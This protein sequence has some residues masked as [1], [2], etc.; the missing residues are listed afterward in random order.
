MIYCGFGSEFGKV[1]VPASAPD[2]NPDNGSRPYLA[3]LIKKMCKK[4]RVFTVRSSNVSHK[5]G[6]W[7][8]VYFFLFFGSGS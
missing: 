8:F 2:S 3:L 5:A 1:P 6:L 4:S 7:F